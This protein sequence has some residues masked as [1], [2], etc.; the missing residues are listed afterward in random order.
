MIL[1][2]NCS[3]ERQLIKLF[4]VLF[5]ETLRFNL[6]YGNHEAT[7]EDMV[8]ATRKAAMHDRILSFP[9]KYE[10]RVGERGQRLS[11]GEKQRGECCLA[12]VESG[13][14]ELTRCAVAIARVILK[15]P[16][17]LLL[18]EVG[19]FRLHKTQTLSVLAQATSALDTTNERAIQQRLREVVRPPSSFS[20][21]AFF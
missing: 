10:T 8:E 18:D 15:N 6:A 20:L 4:A 9:D 21:A 5:N 19:Y 11:G 3:S 17:I 12:K 14:W 16:P 13:C 1:A 2:T 7:E